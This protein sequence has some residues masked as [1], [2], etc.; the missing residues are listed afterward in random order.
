MIYN[1]C[2]LSSYNLLGKNLLL[3]K[4]ARYYDR[5]INLSGAVVL[6]YSPI[7]WPDGSRSDK[8]LPKIS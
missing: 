1:S 3:P 5:L 8:G 7:I 4:K 2:I 6:I